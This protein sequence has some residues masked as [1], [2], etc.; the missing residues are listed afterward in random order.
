MIILI[1]AIIARLL[2][3][4]AKMF[5]CTICNLVLRRENKGWRTNV[6]SAPVALGL[7]QGRPGPHARA[8]PGDR[9]WPGEND[10]KLAQKLGQLQSFLDALPQECTGRLTSY[11]PA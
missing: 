3:K 9:G 1:R 5:R 2:T 7:Q 6:T 10:A 8:K 4:K 11:G